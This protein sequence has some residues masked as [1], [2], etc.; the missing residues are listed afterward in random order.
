MNTLKISLRIF[1]FFTILTGIIYPLIVA[2]AGQLLFRD[3][4]NGSILVRDG[5]AAGSM[6]IGQ[7]FEPAGYFSS[8]PSAANYQTLPSGASNFGITNRKLFDLVTERKSQF[9]AVNQLDENTE[10]PSEMLFA[11]GSG[12]DPDISPKAALLQVERIVK[13]RHLDANGKQLL[14]QSIAGL[15]QPPQYLLL[16]EQRINVLL[17][18]LKLDE[19]SKNSKP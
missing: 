12:L 17:L 1:L 18:N 10:V 4:A 14:L 5:K 2:G 7:Q 8:R 9:L 16:G 15:T 11:S 3:K 13:F 6:L 19:I